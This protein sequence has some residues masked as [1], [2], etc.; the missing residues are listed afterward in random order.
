[1]ANK[2]K[3]ELIEENE[4]LKTER[5]FA[6]EVAAELGRQLREVEE[7]LHAI[8][9]AIKG[10]EPNEPEEKRHRPSDYL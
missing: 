4:R 2:T 1:M 7:R 5:D 8:E 10:G 3:A 6:H 9:V